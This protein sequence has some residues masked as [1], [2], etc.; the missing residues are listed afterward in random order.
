MKNARK[1][2]IDLGINNYT[3]RH[4]RNIEDF[5]SNNEKDVAKLLD[6]LGGW[7]NADLKIAERW[8]TEE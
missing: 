6:K 5:I 8:L 4:L 2:L 7:N 1:L 3:S